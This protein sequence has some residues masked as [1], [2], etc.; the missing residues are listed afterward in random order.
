MTSVAKFI[1]TFNRPDRLREVVE[2]TLGQTRRPDLLLIVDNGDPVPTRKIADTYGV[3]YHSTGSNVGPAGAA[4]FALRHLAERGFDWIAWGDDDTP[5]MTPDTFATLMEL[6]ED[7]PPDVA[8][9]GAVGAR[10]DWATGE[11]RRLHDTEL[12]GPVDVDVIGTGHQLITRAS[13]VDDVGVPDPE[14]FFGFYDPEYCLRIRAAGHRLLVPGELLLEYRKVWN[15]LG[16]D[17]RR[18]VRPRPQPHQL[19]RRYYVTRNY[20]H[21]MRRR[22]DRPD[23]ARR[24]AVKAAFRSVMALLRGPRYARAFVPLQLRGVIDG[25]RSRLGRSVAP[26]PKPRDEVTPSSP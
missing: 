23:L 15:R 1:T 7:A 16:L 8:G 11:I 5:P 12:V 18:S 17:V 26:V 14:L 25:Y 6:A 21:M 9:V 2:A 10:F 20:I 22:F 13:L 19:W 4:A 3:E 24:E